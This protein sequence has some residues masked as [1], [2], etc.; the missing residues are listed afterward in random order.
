MRK[1]SLWLPDVS[2]EDNL[3]KNV[4]RTFA[5]QLVLKKT[6]LR[7]LSPQANYTDQA[8]AACRRS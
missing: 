2:R 3:A 7:A 6:K 1:D 5:Q 8:T 4:P